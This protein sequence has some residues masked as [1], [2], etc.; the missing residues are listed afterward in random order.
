MAEGN[1]IVGNKN[2]LHQNDTGADPY[3]GWVSRRGGAG[4]VI[5][6][7]HVGEEPVAAAE[8]P[9]DPVDGVGAADGGQDEQVDDDHDWGRQQD[10]E[11]DKHLRGK[12]ILLQKKH[13]F[14]QSYMMQ[15]V[16]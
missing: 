15:C 7:P 13:I 2:F 10:D 16:N 8:V 11:A 3:L 12:N 14:V 4:L 9:D 1:F 5:M 6:K